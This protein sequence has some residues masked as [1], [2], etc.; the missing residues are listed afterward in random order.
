MAEKQKRILYV[1]THADDDPEKAA[2]PFV[3]ACAALAMG[4][5]VIITLQGNGVY[6]AQKGYAETIPQGGGF[7]P[8]AEL[9]DNFAELGG[10]LK[11]CVP[12]IKSRNIKEAELLEGTQTT[13]AAALNAE[14]IEADAVMVY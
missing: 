10:M 12:C 13:G 9:M 6:L 3:L 2:M 5:E 7:P 4:I 8:M 1:G 11:V 14:A